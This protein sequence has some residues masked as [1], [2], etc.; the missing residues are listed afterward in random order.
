MCIYCIS[1]THGW[2]Q[3]STISGHLTFIPEKA[4]AAEEREEDAGANME[5]LAT[6][7]IYST[8]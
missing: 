4:N 2:A 1:K 3:I 6:L 5:P 8:E 7:R